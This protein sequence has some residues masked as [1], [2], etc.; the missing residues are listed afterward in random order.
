[1][2]RET[3]QSGRAAMS[4]KDGREYLCWNNAL[5][6][7]LNQIGVNAAPAPAETVLQRLQRE[8]A[9]QPIQPPPT[10]PTAAPGR[11]TPPRMLPRMHQP[12]GALSE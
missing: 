8:A 4:E 1:M 9:T 12:E 11:L 10:S 5:S 7:L 2:D 3:A 6:R